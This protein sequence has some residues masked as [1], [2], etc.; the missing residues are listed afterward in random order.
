[1]SAYAG[2]MSDADDET[3]AATSCTCGSLDRA[4]AEPAVPISFDEKTNE[5]SI[6]YTDGAIQGSVRIRFCYWCGGAAPRSKRAS[7]FAVVTDAEE[8][9]LCDLAGEL[10]TVDEATSRLG[11]PD[12]DHAEGLVTHDEAREGGGPVRTGYRVIRYHKLSPTA[13]LELT[14]FGPGRR[15]RVTVQG[16]YIGPPVTI[17]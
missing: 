8:R 6:I 5:F 16:K 15:L 1:M 7:L 14:D 12:E 10:W 4:A 17:P 3:G 2:L 11:P 9:R 13:I